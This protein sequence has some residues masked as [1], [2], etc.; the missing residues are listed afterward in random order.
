M[1]LV[2]IVSLIVIGVVVLVGVLGY[3]IDKSGEP[4]KHKPERNGA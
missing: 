3:L 2:L 4:V 1:R